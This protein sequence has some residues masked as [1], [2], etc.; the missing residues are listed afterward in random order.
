[1]IISRGDAEKTIRFIT[2]ILSFVFKPISMTSS[3]SYSDS[4]DFSAAS[5]PPRD[6]RW[7]IHRTFSVPDVML[8]D[9]H[10]RVIIQD[11]ETQV[12]H[13]RGQVQAEDTSTLI[14][15]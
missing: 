6:T 12:N 13:K 8:M 10:S 3:L 4:Y 9:F 2:L 1:M 11:S 5:A 15:V 7:L 14:S